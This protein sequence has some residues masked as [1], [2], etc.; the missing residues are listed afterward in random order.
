MATST[1]VLFPSAGS[2]GRMAACRSKLSMPGTNVLSE[3]WNDQ[4]PARFASFTFRSSFS[5]HPFLSLTT[6]TVMLPFKMGS[7]HAS[8]PASRRGYLALISGYP[9]TKRPERCGSGCP[10][11]GYGRCW[12]LPPLQPFRLHH[13]DVPELLLA[14]L[15]DARHS[16][17]LFASKAQSLTCRGNKTNDTQSAISRQNLGV[18]SRPARPTDRKGQQAI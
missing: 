1:S 17:C 15:Q 16:R 11:F 13:I 5:V 7:L 9:S 3:Q 4:T 8:R 6:S 18:S 10:G 12:T 14:M 2:A